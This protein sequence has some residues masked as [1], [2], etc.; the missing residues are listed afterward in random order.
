MRAADFYLGQAIISD[1]VHEYIRFTVPVADGEKTEKDLIDSPWLQRLRCILQLQGARWV[2]PSADHTRF[3]HSLGAMHV[4]GCFARH[5]CGSLRQVFRKK[6][7]SESLVEETIRLA[8]LLH[9]VGHGPL[10]HFFDHHFLDKYG[11]THEDLGQRIIVDRLG[12]VIRGIR[13]SPYADFKP[14]EAIDPQW[15]AY[16]I[17][18]GASPPQG[19]PGW[20]RLFKPLF[21][22]IYTVDNLDYVLRDSY[23]CGVA[24]GPIDVDRLLHYTFFSPK[25]LTLHRAGTGALRMFVNARLYLYSAVY[26]H[27]TNRAI[28]L[29]LQEIFR[30]TL[31]LIFGG[32]PLD[33][34][35]SYLHLTDW[36]VLQEVQRW[37]S[38]RAASKQDLAAEWS[39]ILER[40]VKWKTAF[41]EDL[42]FTQLE[43]GIAPMSSDEFEQRIRDALPAGLADVPFEVDMAPLDPRPVNPADMGQRQIFLYDPAMDVSRERLADLLRDIPFR[44]VNCRVYALSHDHDAALAAAARNALQGLGGEALPTSV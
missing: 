42:L 29:H 40:K 15:L 14:G 24:V 20:V 18:R 36:Y 2:F 34:I 16:L 9:D 11:I 26:Y 22:G 10:G 19:C 21:E 7:P 3:Q 12:D 39:R 32:N 30:P 37:G 27:R 43:P 44:L 31:R 5:L 25:G 6:R 35:D 1:P 38:A 13:R 4:A 17:K 28:E 41:E 23:M 8:G 33:E